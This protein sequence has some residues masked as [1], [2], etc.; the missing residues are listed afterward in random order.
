MIR[1]NSVLFFTYLRKLRPV[2]YIISYERKMLC[3]FQIFRLCVLR[4]GTLR[5]DTYGSTVRYD[6]LQFLTLYY[7]TL[8]EGGK[9]A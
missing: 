5:I 2:T 4:Y 6:T 8:H 9:R 7:V 1:Q 3:M